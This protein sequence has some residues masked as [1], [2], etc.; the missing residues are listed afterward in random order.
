M[1]RHFLLRQ[2]CDAEYGLRYVLGQ[3]I[4]VAWLLVASLISIILPFSSRWRSIS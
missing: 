4:S 1:I 2:G 3:A